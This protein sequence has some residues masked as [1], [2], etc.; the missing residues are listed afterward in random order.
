M[1]KKERKAKYFRSVAALA[2]SLM[3]GILV[4][5]QNGI[6][7]YADG[8][9]TVKTGGKIR[10]KASTSSEVL[11]SVEKDDTLDIIAQTK[12]GS[13][14]TWYKVYINS[15]KQGYIRADLV[16]VSGT[17]PNETASN[18]TSQSNQSTKKPAATVTTETDVLTAKVTSPKQAVVR[19]GAGT[20]CDSVAGANPG[21]VVSVSGE[22]KDSSG[23]IWYKVSYTSE[24]KTVTG[25]IRADLLTVET[26]TTDQPA[27]QEPVQE[28]PAPEVS[29]P[30]TSVTETPVQDEIMIEDTLE[31]QDYY[32]KYLENDK[33]EMN[34]YLFDNVKETS[35][36]LQQMLQVIEQLEN[37]DV[38]ENE[39][40]SIMKFLVMGMAVVM[41]LLIIVILIL[42]SKL[43]QT[44]RKE[45]YE[46]Y[47][48]YE[49]DDEVEYEDE[50]DQEEAVTKKNPFRS[51]K[52]KLKKKEEV[53]EE[54]YEYEEYEE[55]VIPQA[56]KQVSE[57]ATRTVENT[58]NWDANEVE[59]DD[60]MEFEFLDL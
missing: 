43:K 11:A 60:D 56:T 8:T 35:R 17:I 6:A 28:T 34:W 4:W 44:G 55:E 38:K 18:T 20:D 24:N 36:N 13:G 9:A 51:L 15:E 12:D 7:S 47:E 42:V 21:T 16:K 52:A 3:F 53:A 57:P 40:G 25:F 19:N 49:E 48:E 58:T 22:A 30:E 26:R 45:E 41:I 39:Q 1:L 27:V 33:G 31:S 23:K 50:E 29:V 46:E 59:L 2:F 32:L 37:S 14:Y 10:E 54:E 5:N